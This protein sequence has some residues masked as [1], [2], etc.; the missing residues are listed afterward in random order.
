[1]PESRE[2]KWENDSKSAQN[3]HFFIFFFSKNHNLKKKKNEKSCFIFVIKIETLATNFMHLQVKMTSE[4]CQKVVRLNL[5]IAFIKRVVV[6]LHP[7]LNVISIRFNFKKWKTPKNFFYLINIANSFHYSHFIR[8]FFKV[9]LIFNF[10]SK[11][12]LSYRKGD[13]WYPSSTT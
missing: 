7:K 5:K 9:P 2:F 1:M 4:I 12:H 11:S 3:V 13:F 6:Q 10:C 8:E